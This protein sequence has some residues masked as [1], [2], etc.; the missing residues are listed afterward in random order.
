MINDHPIAEITAHP[1]DQLGRQRNLGK[2]VKDIA[3]CGEPFGH[4]MNINFRLAAAR[5]PV[6]QHHLLPGKS[7]A[8]RLIRL[9]LGVGQH[10]QRSDHGT[11]YGKRILP[12]RL[13][14]QIDLPK[15]PAFDQRPDHSG[16]NTQRRPGNQRSL[17]ESEST[18]PRRSNRNLPV[19]KISCRVLRC[20]RRLRGSRIILFPGQKSRAGQVFHYRTMLG[21]R[22]RQ[23]IERGMQLLLA[24]DSRMQADVRH[25]RRPVATA[26]RL[27]LGV[28]VE[29]EFG[30]QR[31]THHHSRGTHIIRA[32]P[33][34]Q[35][36]LFGRGRFALIDDPDDGFNSFVRRRFVMQPADDSGVKL[37]RTELYHH[38]HA[39]PQAGTHRFVHRERH[40][41]GGQRKYYIGISH[42]LQRQKTARD[43]FLP[44][45]D[46]DSPFFIN[47]GC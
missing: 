47:P 15:N 11:L 19:R 28:T 44:G 37:P 27:V 7:A 16:R 13:P 39:R 4:Q 6:Q 18:F 45:S 43:S 26:Q 35:P 30:R 21:T 25:E 3:A 14:L 32:D 46:K 33:L 20:R 9:L 29:F 31:R 8:D 24:A 10:R 41:R 2:H 42:E 23:R 40:R 17:A 1:L 36:Q 5:H 38:P 22:T 12:A 34:P